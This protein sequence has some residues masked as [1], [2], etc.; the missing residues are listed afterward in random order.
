MH[1]L[2]PCVGHYKAINKL[3]NEENK[4]TQN[5]YIFGVVS[6]SLID[7]YH[8]DREI[9]KNIIF[10]LSC[11]SCVISWTHLPPK[12]I[13]TTP[14]ER[15]HHNI[16]NNQRNQN[17]HL[18]HQRPALPERQQAAIGCLAILPEAHHCHHSRGQLS[19]KRQ[20]QGFEVLVEVMLWPFRQRRPQCLWRDLQHL[21]CSTER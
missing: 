4:R 5:L 7:Y 18:N 14:Q 8:H 6:F 16:I 15:E 13:I 12:N 17:D 3:I 10:G 11:V 9:T 21:W 1:V 20:C 2:V 19:W